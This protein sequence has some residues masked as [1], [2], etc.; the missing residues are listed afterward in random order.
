MS[1]ISVYAKAMGNAYDSIEQRHEFRLPP[2]YRALAA[3]GFLEYGD[4]P[5]GRIESGKLLQLHDVEWLP[6]TEI[7]AFDSKARKLRPRLVPFAQNGAGDLWCWDVAAAPIGGEPPIVVT[8]YDEDTTTVEAHDFATW[9]YLAILRLFAWNADPE[10][11]RRFAAVAAITSPHLAVDHR[12]LV[13]GFAHRA[14]VERKGGEVS[15]L[16]PEEERAHSN[17]VVIPDRGKHAPLR[18]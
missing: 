12:R 1:A 9:L 14:P 5:R 17:A 10:L 3:S 18:A 7:T 8:S 13:E 6:P 11:A 16:T 4:D 15:V 2:A